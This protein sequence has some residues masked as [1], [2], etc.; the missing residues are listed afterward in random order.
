M[1]IIRKKICLDEFRS[2]ICG[3]LPYCS[4]STTDIIPSG[5]SGNFGGFVKDA[6]GIEICGW[7]GN[8]FTSDG[9]NLIRTTDMMRRYNALLDILRNSLHLIH[10]KNF[11]CQQTGAYSNRFSDDFE[12]TGTTDDFIF[13]EKTG[14]YYESAFTI[15]GNYY[16]YEGDSNDYVILISDDDAELYEKYHG[17]GFVKEVHEII[18]SGNTSFSEVPYIPIHI[19]LTNSF[20][21]IG[22]MSLYED[23]MYE[24]GEF[25]KD[26]S[27]SDF[28]NEFDYF[29]KSGFTRYI[30]D[31]G[32][33]YTEEP[34][35][36]ESKL[37]TLRD[38]LYF[39][40]DNGTT[41]PAIFEDFSGT[42][43]DEKGKFFKC[44]YCTGLTTGI[45][46]YIY[47]KPA[48]GTTW[49]LSST[50][51][52]MNY[53]WTKHNSYKHYV[54]CPKEY[55]T[56]R[57][58]NTE[59]ND[60]NTVKTFTTTANTKY[61]WWEP[62]PTN[63]NNLICADDENVAKNQEKYRT[64][65][66]FE[67]L[68]KQIEKTGDTGLTDGDYYYFL[69]KY[70]NAEETPARIPFSENV[71][72]NQEASEYNGETIYT[73]DL[74][75]GIS[76][77]DNYINFTYIL[78]AIFSDSGY[79][80]CSG[81]TIYKETYPYI[82]NEEGQID[83]DGFTDV[84]YWY[85]YVDFD[86]TKQQIINK[87]FNLTKEVNIADIVGMTT[88][89]VWRKDGSVYNSPLIKE[90]YLMGI[91]M[92]PVTD[93]DVE[94]DRGNA[95]AFERHFRLSECN[96]LQDLEENGNGFYTIE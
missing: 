33:G 95:A 14:V 58:T 9:E 70:D 73:G 62:E 41:I 3:A 78:G 63:G 10:N 44:Y 54:L 6:K 30:D 19:L 68:I 57:H 61:S 5:D 88:G 40:D 35:K 75:S 27:G 31:L 94:I 80:N 77:I 8:A 87:D 49:N 28:D 93:I 86:G 4:G 47:I 50:S 7:T 91:T 64:L 84:S 83:I 79:T 59:I 12:Y 74:I 1:E 2:H 18:Y 25:P 55:N 45:T 89:D 67:T 39:Q 38:K 22:I 46:T 11:S 20:D 56:T 36:L 48:T 96:T 76:Y 65:T 82:T 42:T 71:V 34:A 66:V 60:E 81:G 92:N 72:F 69:V 43:E 26:F 37:L 24:W 53:P 17:I 15:N 29:E 32:Q 51:S 13:N 16:I 52:T 21:S 23:D 90:D 85:N